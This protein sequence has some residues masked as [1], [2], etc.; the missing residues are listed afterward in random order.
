MSTAQTIATP[1]RERMI[2]DMLTCAVRLQVSDVASSSSSISLFSSNGCVAAQL[3]GVTYASAGSINVI[4]ASARIM[5]DDT[6]SSTACPDANINATTAFKLPQ[7]YQLVWKPFDAA[8]STPP[9]SLPG[10]AIHWKKYDGYNAGGRAVLKEVYSQAMGGAV[11]GFEVNVEA[12]LDR[13]RQTQQTVI[14]ADVT[15]S[16][17]GDLDET[18]CVVAAACAEMLL[19]L[20]EAAADAA[21]SAA[22]TK[23]ASK[24]SSSPAPPCPMY[25]FISCG[26]TRRPAVAALVALARGLQLEH[27]RA[28]GGVIDFDVDALQKQRDDVL[29]GSWRPATV[30]DVVY[31]TS[32]GRDGRCF[33][34]RLMP[35]YAA[36]VEECVAGVNARPG[37]PAFGPSCCV[38]GGTSGLGLAFARAAAAS[39]EVTSLML[40]SRA[41]R[42]DAVVKREMETKGCRV[43]VVAADVRD[44]NAMS[45]AMKVSSSSSSGGR[46]GVLNSIIWAAG[47]TGHA[48]LAKL[49]D[50]ECWEVLAPKVAA[51]FI[52]T[53]EKC[54]KDTNVILISSVSSVWGHSGA[55]HYA[56]ANAYLDALA[57]R[58]SASGHSTISVRF[59]P[60]AGTGM[61]S[62]EDEQVL[63]RVGLSALSPGCVL[64]VLRSLAGTA[65][66]GVVVANLNRRVFSRVHTAALGREW[67]L[68]QDLVGEEQE[69]EQQ[70]AIE[71]VASGSSERRLGGKTTARVAA[72]LPAEIVIP[73]ALTIS[74]ATDILFQGLAR[75][76]G[77]TPEPDE[78][79]VDAGLDSLTAVELADWLS[80][81]TGLELPQTMVFDHPTSTELAGYLARQS[82]IANKR[83]SKAA[84]AA[85]AVA[86]V[87][88]AAAAA[89]A[90]A[91]AATASLSR[92]DAIV[93]TVREG[94]DS[95][96]A[97]IAFVAGVT[98][99]D[100]AFGT[101]DA[102]CLVSSDAIECV[103]MERWSVESAAS[104]GAFGSAGT[105]A[106]FGAF[107]PSA[108]QF[109]TQY[110]GMR[111]AE[112]VQSDPQH[113]LLLQIAS[114]LQ[115]HQAGQRAGANANTCVTVGITAMEYAAI[116]ALALGPLG[117]PVAA[118]GSLNVAAGRVSYAL[119][120]RG[121]AMAVDTA[122]SS[123]L[124]GAHVGLT[125][126]SGT[127][128]YASSV[129]S[130]GTPAATGLHALALG[131]NLTLSEA[132]SAACAAAG[133][134]SPAGRC[135]TL[136]VAAD[137]Y[138][139]GEACAGLKLS[140][141]RRGMG[142]S[143]GVGASAMIVL[144]GA[145]VNQD[146][147]SSSLTTP[148]GPA[149]SRVI[150]EAIAMACLEPHHV[151]SLSMHG[152]GTALGDPIEI[153][154][155]VGALRG[156]VDDEC[157]GVDAGDGGLAPPL[158]PTALKSHR[159]HT[160]SAS[161]VL[162]LVHVIRGLCTTDSPDAAI[163][164]I[165][166]MNPFVVSA[167][168]SAAVE[169]EQSLFVTR[170]RAPSILQGG[171]GGLPTGVS[172]F[173][174]SGT[175]T[176]AIVKK[177]ISSAGASVSSCIVSTGSHRLAESARLWVLPAASALLTACHVAS[178]VSASSPLFGRRC[179]IQVNVE[180]ITR[181]GFDACSPSVAL[182]T[183]V[184]AASRV[185][186]WDT[187][188][189]S[190]AGMRRVVRKVHMLSVGAPRGVAMMTCG[191]DEISGS[192]DVQL[193]PA[194]A[195][196]GASVV[197][198]RASVENV[199]SDVSA[200]TV[201]RRQR[202]DL[203]TALMCPEI[204]VAEAPP[205]SARFVITGGDPHAAAEL[206]AVLAV[207]AHAV[208]T[209][210]T[211][212]THPSLIETVIG[213]GSAAVP[214]VQ[215]S[216]CVTQTAVTVSS[217]SS[218]ASLF[219]ASGIVSVPRKQA[220]AEAEAGAV[221]EARV[222]AYS[223]TDAPASVAVASVSFAVDVLSGSTTTDEVSI[224]AQ[225]L[226]TI[227]EVLDDGS[228]RAAAGGTV[229][230]GSVGLI[231]AGL[232]SLGVME[233]RAALQ[234]A[235]PGITLPPSLMYD[236]PTVDDVVRLV[237]STVAVAATDYQNP[238]RQSLVTGA[239]VAG[240]L[241]GSDT[242]DIR[243][244]P[245]DL[246][247]AS[248]LT[249]EQYLFWSH[250]LMFPN[251]SAY[252][253]G[254]VLQF[255]EPEVDQEDLHAAVMRVVQSHPA[256]LVYVS[257]DGTAL[258]QPTVSQWKTVLA[259]A[260]KIRRLPGEASE[261]FHSSPEVTVDHP[262]VVAACSEPFAI[263]NSAPLRFYRAG[264]KAL[265]LVVHHV[266]CDASSLSLLA[267]QL[268]ASHSMIRAARL[269]NG[270]TVPTTAAQL[271]RAL[272]EFGFFAHA[273]AQA[274]QSTA[275]QVEKVDHWEELLMGGAGKVSDASGISVGGFKPLNLR[276]DYPPPG[277]GGGATVVGTKRA[278]ASISI[279]I[280]PRLATMLRSGSASKGRTAFS[281]LISAWAL[282]LRRQAENR[283]E[284]NA[285]AGTAAV[286]IDD[287]VFGTAFDLRSMTS[288][289]T[290]ETV[291]CFSTLLPVRCNM[292][293]VRAG[294]GS[295][296]DLAGHMHRVC[297]SA[298]KHPDVSL[299]G[300]IERLNPP[301][302]A[303]S[304]NPLFS[305]CFSFVS[306]PR[307]SEGSSSANVND[308][309]IPEVTAVRFHE[310]A[311]ELWL[312]IGEI[313]KGGMKGNL[314]YDTTVFSRRTATAL[315]ASFKAC[316]ERAVAEP[317]VS[318]D[319]LDRHILAARAESSVPRCLALP[320]ESAQSA[321][322]RLC[323]VSG[324]VTASVEPSP[325]GHAWRFLERA[326]ATE[327]AAVGTVVAGSDGGRAM[328]RDVADDAVMSYADLEQQARALA[329]LL[330]RAA[331]VVGSD[332]ARPRVSVLGSN[333]SGILTI[334]FAAAL[335]GGVVGNH[336]THLVAPELA[337]QLER[338]EPHAIAIVGR[339]DS[340]NALADA[341]LALVER[342]GSTSALPHRIPVPWQTSD[343]CALLTSGPEA[344]IDIAGTSLDVADGFSP[345]DPYML[346]FTS[347][348]SGK[349]KGVMLTQDIVCRHAVGTMSEMRLH[350]ED[351]WLH[352]APMFHLVDAF[353]IYAITAA[354]GQHVLQPSFEATATL[355]VIEREGVTVLN[356]ASTM[357]ALM[358]AS[359]TLGLVDLSSLRLVSCGGSP[360]AAAVV[361]RAISAF[362]CEFFVSYGM[363]ECCG[364]IT[365]SLLESAQRD[366]NSE[367]TAGATF[368]Q[369]LETMCKSGRPFRLQTVRVVAEDGSVVQPG[370]G[371]V[372]EVQCRGP[373]V[374]DG[375]WNDPE[376]TAKSFEVAAPEDAQRRSWFRT[377]DL[378][379]VDSRG[380]LS[381]V[382]RKTDM[383]LV[384]GENVYTAEV[385]SALHAHPAVKQAA[386]FG[387]D[388]EIL[389]QMV[390]AA[391]VL[392]PS[393]PGRSASP[394]LT[395]QELI[396]HAC[397]LLSAYKVPAVLKFVESLP[398]GGSGKVLKTK[399]RE[400]A[401]ASSLSV[402]ATKQK[403]QQPRA[404]VGGGGGASAE[405]VSSIFS[406]SSA[407]SASGG[408]AYEEYAVEWVA[409]PAATD[410]VPLA[411]DSRV[412][413]N[414][415][416]SG[417]S[418]K[419]AG[420]AGDMIGLLAQIDDSL[421]APGVSGV[422]V[423]SRG[424]SIADKVVPS[425]RTGLLR[426]VIAERQSQRSGSTSVR[427][428]C[429]VGDVG[430]V[431]V[432]AVPDTLLLPPASAEPEVFIRRT[433]VFVPR[434]TLQQHHR[435]GPARSTSLSK[436][437]EAQLCKESSRYLV[438]V[439][440][441]ADI[442]PGGVA[443]AAI[444]TFAT[445]P[446]CQSIVV[447]TP[448]APNPAGQ[449]A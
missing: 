139:R 377:G 227:A 163:M 31:S 333:G 305:T 32:V 384:G 143:S 307:F 90:A 7:L 59:G 67:D 48:P 406:P 389:G 422:D 286:P 263:T 378:A 66:N 302:R 373:T 110:F 156:D 283:Q 301:R 34:A 150:V 4:D 186:G 390:H 55:A 185:T 124:V 418:S 117:V 425:L 5:I 42:L 399:L 43:D 427:H 398:M 189:A 269:K 349:P 216:G 92:D 282:T 171:R 121:P 87:A 367:A 141:H 111:A 387:V 162:G 215:I 341:A 89:T 82:K 249:R 392:R 404:R 175:N 396:A 214:N 380:Y 261:D 265:L 160:E 244:M 426:G 448:A 347:G 280:P 99:V 292:G 248:T 415:S 44:A 179:V 151:T 442:A 161:G 178:L 194:A 14:G 361:K 350:S 266:V 356:M 402:T 321:V 339:S 383:V 45:D 239:S 75:I 95:R 369:Q 273:A 343:I 371:V 435:G 443:A 210:A 1:I 128:Y 38:T 21:V 257:S 308:N 191:V 247:A 70:Q 97:V 335:V 157:D 294:D 46:A 285:A 195:G 15:D 400:M 325:L 149:Q 182:A 25:I 334:H 316:L 56:A 80:T 311:F 328:I 410:W 135:K 201:T 281:T 93:L 395:Q 348:T 370:S 220:E 71:L 69:L 129:I 219:H 337:Y 238:Q 130:G 439:E 430:G 188:S 164:H 312:G 330:R 57:V 332:G 196:G 408:S 170:Q 228:D 374:F 355:R 202:E 327:A 26:A 61:I 233:L 359:P 68:L 322:A 375:Y 120:L 277:E 231:E 107:V 52:N 365:M 213:D 208:C 440:S 441:P 225:V 35:A 234:R 40:I 146:G 232:D 276:L 449:C 22:A 296:E 20:R 279:D 36:L 85:A 423:I 187:G 39:R 340:L 313:A 251:S 53:S 295:F 242:V 11:L 289:S 98:S 381:V 96:G 444:Q 357:V 278:C 411:S 8:S 299:L 180:A 274:R 252:N 344:S 416:A 364:K 3:A 262:A 116:A 211:Q 240:A 246:A 142:A 138:V 291:G 397:G 436:E 79:L 41:G 331:L 256:L 2:G 354:A 183:A 284:A 419:A 342:Q 306:L 125:Y 13:A 145:A 29:G 446:S 197:S 49:S 131:V 358:C 118:T 221:A 346:Y 12:I 17:Q 345:Q 224:R 173:G 351:V 314:M 51:S 259:Q 222:V 109:D 212:A 23:S 81:N 115:P 144:S 401:V 254:F 258:V 18:P 155:A 27:P 323:D 50:T 200:P 134:L 105:G 268:R 366:N 104:D 267:Q 230:N 420:M 76:L 360:L 74:E 28:Y 414:A 445:R 172:A 184:A 114:R 382:D 236:C 16:N 209:G 203:F 287:L 126:V 324:G 217:S 54:G 204:F 432:W 168:R 288:L 136:D 275:D 133:M 77:E 226:K 431:D 363:T 58:R 304:G 250:S 376:A 298:F 319:A 318:V 434:L 64:N 290:S 127:S 253:M 303:G 237:I 353:A 122:C 317:R 176:H 428:I 37:S 148:N 421:T 243:A 372:G 190:E 413:I 424:A 206:S 272:A 229:M 72:A 100:A 78:P 159:G 33:A 326:V 362:G 147:K 379:T 91:A 152:T 412:R 386:V 119:D 19:V 60:F 24:S 169:G 394:A 417:G 297:R 429:V 88:V 207:H 293:D 205:L 315:A 193:T 73:A 177:Q 409:I 83:A 165:R 167:A 255:D 218:P 113:R 438:V 166:T 86:A 437:E 62:A 158:R 223:D 235:V 199:V 260:T 94:G 405:A 403:Q 6:V 112:A 310:A 108:D 137:G 271:P 393:R 245:R 368:S 192:I 241:S 391:V 300:I 320:L 63:E 433:E 270:G 154:A 264:K 174:F 102:G 30:S 447:W 10:P 329:A 153:G 336:N 140:G 181:A 101:T 132:A 47:V 385:E 84:A 198:L 338:F 123:S 9:S 103:P 407:R 309:A 352:A 388:N 106:R 65:A